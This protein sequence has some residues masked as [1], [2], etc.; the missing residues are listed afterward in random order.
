MD[1]CCPP[2][3]VYSE[4]AEACVCTGVGCC[5]DGFI[6]LPNGNCGCGSDAVCPFGLT[7]E[8]DTGRCVCTGPEDCASD[9]FCNEF[10]SCQSLMG[11]GSNLDCP[12]GFFCHV[13]AAQCLEVGLCGDDAHCTI[14]Q[15]CDPIAQACVTGCHGTGDCPLDSVCI[16]GQCEAGRC[17]DSTLCPLRSF[18]DVDAQTCGSPDPIHCRSCDAGCG[19]DPCVTSVVEG[20]GAVG[21]CG[22]ECV[23]DD[24]CPGGMG[25]ADTYFSCDP[26]T[27]GECESEGTICLETEVLNEPPRGFCSDPVTRMPKVLRHYCAPRTGFCPP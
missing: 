7:C 2:E 24:D 17:E 16:A 13:S 11:C 20:I 8:L 19:D 22:I 10:G 23:G 6:E 14:G 5:P 26:A 15:I 25:C 18:C 27:S 9:S 4:Q 21:V 1:E 3:H 12:D